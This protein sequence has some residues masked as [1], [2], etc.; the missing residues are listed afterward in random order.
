M[1]NQ[2]ADGKNQTSE[3][4]EQPVREKEVSVDQQSANDPDIEKSVTRQ[5]RA[6]VQ[7]PLMHESY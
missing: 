3:I 7:N 1:Q 5:R 6:E 2:S 4:E